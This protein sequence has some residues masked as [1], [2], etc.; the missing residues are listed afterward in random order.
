MS[1]IPEPLD[2][3]HRLSLVFGFTLRHLEALRGHR[4]GEDPTVSLSR[5]DPGILRRGVE[6]LDARE[7]R[8]RS[9]R[10]RARCDRAGIRILAYGSDGYP[11]SLTRIADA[12][13]ILYGLGSPASAP[14]AIALVGSRAAT[15]AGMEFARRLSAD[16]AFAGITVVSGMARGIDSSAHEGALRSGGETIA[17]LGC[18]VDVLYPPESRGL[19]GRI[20]DRGGLLSEFPPGTLPLRHHFPM[21]NRLVSGL[22]LGVVVIEA[23]AKSGALITARIALEQGREVMAVPGSPLFPHTAGSNRLLREGATPVTGAEDVLHA[24]GRS[25]NRAPAPSDAESG[26]REERV[27]RLLGRW[28]HVDEISGRLCI[29]VPELFP[30]LFDLEFRKLLE[31]RAGDYYKKTSDRGG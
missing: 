27:L 15:D 14:D 9:D 8:E 24:V 28:R 17:V 5:S 23:P 20:R 3:L 30:L 21:R 22:A 7:S 11:E 10:I 6:S 12:P 2:V 29:P 1:N 25:G 13:L 26:E 19:R 18:G 31:R 4:S 16:L